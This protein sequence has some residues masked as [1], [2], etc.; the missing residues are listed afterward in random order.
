MT[1]PSSQTSKTL[2]PSFCF[3][4]GTKREIKHYSVMV[5]KGEDQVEYLM[6]DRSEW[7]EDDE[8]RAIADIQKERRIRAEADHDVKLRLEAPKPSAKFLK[9]TTAPPPSCPPRNAHL[10]LEA[11]RLIMQ[12]QQ[13]EAAAEASRKA[14]EEKKMRQARLGGRVR[15]YER[16]RCTKKALVVKRE[17]RDQPPRPATCGR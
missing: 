7:I 3:L 4:T 6:R 12:K 15:L 16:P 14:A 9:P 1:S 11:D 10:A 5:E 17:A 8:N 13:D 2:T